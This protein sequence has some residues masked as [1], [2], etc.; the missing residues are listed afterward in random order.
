MKSN[1]P[2]HDWDLTSLYAL[3]VP[4]ASLIGLMSAIRG[5]TLSML[6]FSG[7]LAFLGFYLAWIA[8]MEYRAFGELHCFKSRPL[9]A[10]IL[11]AAFLSILQVSR[12][13]DSVTSSLGWL[14]FF[15]FTLVAWET[16]TMACGFDKYFGRRSVNRLTIL[17]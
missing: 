2:V 9:D 11:A 1:N 10:F 13:A 7:Y 14:T 16:Y 5:P 4:V 8:G 3:A 12:N 6:T 15:L 17:A